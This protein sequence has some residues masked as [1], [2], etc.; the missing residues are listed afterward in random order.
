MPA[1]WIGGKSV[2]IGSVRGW[3]PAVSRVRRSITICAA[4]VARIMTNIV[5]LRSH[6]G[7]T[8]SR[9]STTPSKATLAIATTAA[10]ANGRP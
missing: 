4:S 6:S 1:T 8:T 7:R 10:T 2:N 9:S 5:D 3:S